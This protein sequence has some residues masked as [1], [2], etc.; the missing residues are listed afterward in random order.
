MIDAILK[1]TI[2]NNNE[3]KVYR[4]KLEKVCLEFESIFIREMM[5]AMRKT[6]P[7]TGFFGND[8]RKEIFESLF[9]AEIS[10]AISNRGG[11]GIG[12]LMYRNMLKKIE[13]KDIFSIDE[14]EK[15]EKRD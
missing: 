6:I 12:K 7:K 2:Q 9:D 1:T 5:K 4:N 15:W 8:S 11:L 14:G 13:N 3:N 10:K